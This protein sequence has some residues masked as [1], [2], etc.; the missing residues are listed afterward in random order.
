MYIYVCV[1]VSV[2]VHVCMCVGL[3]DFVNLFLGYVTRQHRK[4]K[5]EEATVF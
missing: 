3:D 4:K 1:S 5:I 2:C